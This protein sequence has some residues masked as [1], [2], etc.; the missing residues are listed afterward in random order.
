MD[1]TREPCR[2]EHR[3]PAQA[4]ETA[5]AATT[6]TS[7]SPGASEALRFR[8][9]AAKELDFRSRRANSWRPRILP[10]CCGA[11]PHVA[12]HR[13]PRDGDERARL[14]TLIKRSGRAAHGLPLMSRAGPMM[15]MGTQPGMGSVAVPHVGAPLTSRKLGPSALVSRLRIR[16]PRAVCTAHE[17]P[18]RRYES[19]L[20]PHSTDAHFTPVP[21]DC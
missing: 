15:F 8:I 7:L 10:P 5:A 17:E 6:G 16:L 18:N 1:A 19:A 3:L 12:A 9:I 20:M 13:Q 11:G 14:V 21:L 4:T 2:A